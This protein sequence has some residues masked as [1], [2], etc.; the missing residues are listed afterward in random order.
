MM[1]KLFFLLAATKNTSRIVQ[2]HIL[3]SMHRDELVCFVFLLLFLFFSLFFF[4]H[5]A[6]WCPSQYI[7]DLD[8]PGLSRHTLQK[9]SRGIPRG[10]SVVE[11][12]LSIWF[13]G[14]WIGFSWNIERPARGLN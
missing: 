7:L 4:A 3:V 12:R 10:Q 13:G 8:T 5:M 2:Q 11:D 6:C 14:Y 1:Y 9:T